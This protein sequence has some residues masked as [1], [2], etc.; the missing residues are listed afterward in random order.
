MPQIEDK[1]PAQLKFEE[2]QFFF[3]ESIFRTDFKKII[4]MCDVSK[5]LKTMSGSI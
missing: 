2:Q 1:Y 3:F 4:S 5:V